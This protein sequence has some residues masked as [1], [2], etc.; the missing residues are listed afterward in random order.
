VKNKIQ[1]GFSLVEV[2]SAV[3]IISLAI[4]A[5][6]LALPSAADSVARTE[7]R[8]LALKIAQMVTEDVKSSIESYKSEFYNGQRV[9]VSTEAFNIQM[10]SGEPF[11]TQLF[12]ITAG[13]RLKKTGERSNANDFD[14]EVQVLPKEATTSGPLFLGQHL[15]IKRRRSMKA[16]ESTLI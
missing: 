6:F 11:N 14:V 15:E 9:R 10:K 4:S 16:V 5:V 7:K 13:G 2:L 12:G 1:S 8:T 3:L